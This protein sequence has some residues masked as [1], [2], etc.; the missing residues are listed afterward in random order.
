LTLILKY[1]IIVCNLYFEKGFIMQ[2]NE[3][4]LS[5]ELLQAVEK[6]G[7][8]EMTEI[9]QKSIPLLLEGR[10]V[11][12]RSNT[13]TG[14]TAA[15]GIP[16]VES[17]CEND[18]NVTVLILCPTR[19]L[20]MQACGELKKFSEFKKYIRVCAVYGGASMEK[21]IHEL[22]RGVN[23]VVGTPGRVMDHMRRKTLKLD[24]LR[25]IILDEADEMLNM[26]FREDIE[27]ILKSVPE[28]RQTVLFSATMPPAILAITKEYQHDPVTV[29]I[30]EKH[31]TVDLIDQYWFEVAMGRK[32]DALKLLLSAYSPK[33]AM[34]F[35]NTK[36]MVDEL[37]EELTKSSFR[38]MGLHGDMKQTQRTQV[39]NSFK[40]GS[41][42]ILIATDVAA[43]GIDVNGIDAVFN[44]D[45]PQDN[46]YYI[47]R[48]GR[49]GRAG[50]KGTAYTLIS[51]RKQIYALKDISRFTKAEIT[52]LPLPHKSD[53]VSLK[54]NKI[55]E[56]TIN[57]ENSPS[58]ESFSLAAR[59]LDSGMTPEEIIAGLIDE[60]IQSEISS[61]PEF[62]IPAPLRKSRRR[63]KEKTVKIEISIGRN[64]HIAPNFI[65][66]A[67]VDATGM[68]GR[69]FGKIDIFDRHTTVEIP[70]AETDYVLDSMESAKINGHKVN[71]KL[72][73]GKN[74]DKGYSKS[75][76]KDKK[77]AHLKYRE[78][79]PKKTQ[80]IKKRH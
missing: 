53:I 27:T 74:S 80:R 24:N 47:H 16:A 32:T 31:R 40:S 23:I 39:M 68:P 66:G 13:G 65:L 33:S 9:Q 30:E 55:F 48:I 50:H 4:N 79:F 72:Y 45:L 56:Q 78:S 2:F 58:H 20:A 12:G 26:G 46:E 64:Q 42:S 57:K 25:T 19:E 10:D 77:T 59:L 14:K 37:T 43:R 17:I 60:K 67:L 35:C 63:D 75:G 11:T 61:L 15:F 28:K 49:T 8:S 71:V 22:K 1:D 54:L 38:V 70:E 6:L 29:K 62:D 3:L 34:I 52:E 41:V 21:Q 7:F 51:G 69:D 73:T 76:K 18:R 36:K 5:Q 44:Y